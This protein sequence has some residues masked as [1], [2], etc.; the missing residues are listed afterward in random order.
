[1]DVA[2]EAEAELDRHR[3][4]VA[5]AVDGEAEQ[6]HARLPV[7]DQR[8]DSPLVDVVLELAGPTLTVTI[9][10]TPS[11]LTASTSAAGSCADHGDRHRPELTPGRDQLAGHVTHLAAQVLGDD[12]YAHASRSFTIARSGRDL[13]GAAVEH[14]GSR[15]A[16]GDE[17]PAD[18]VGGRSAV[19]RAA[20][21]ISTCS[22]CLIARRFA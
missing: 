14:L 5:H 9:S 8:L 19:R 16:L 12:Q 17:H 6:R 10:S 21:S 4:A 13:R 22:A 11:T 20:T 3:R 7:D 2:R 18:A 1:M 15:P